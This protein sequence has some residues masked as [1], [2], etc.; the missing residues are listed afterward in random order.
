ME[1]ADWEQMI[2]S[3]PHLLLYNPLKFNV[4]Q[5]GA[6]GADVLK[7]FSV[8]SVVA[9]SFCSSL[10]RAYSIAPFRLTHNTIPVNSQHHSD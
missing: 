8:W 6:D 10:N 7:T 4:L 1:I 9:H 3:A 5:M 2:L